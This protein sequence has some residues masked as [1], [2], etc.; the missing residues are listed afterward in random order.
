MARIRMFVLALLAS[1]G[2]AVPAFAADPGDLITQIAAAVS[3]SSMMTSITSI[4][5]SVV[6][7]VI[8]VVGFIL[9]LSLIRK[10]RG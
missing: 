4:S 2:F 5:S 10:A 1:L 8:G 6:V 9:I 7:V 3:F